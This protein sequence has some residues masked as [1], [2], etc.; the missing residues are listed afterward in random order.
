[1][2]M[3]DHYKNANS[4]E[5]ILRDHLAYDRTV[6]ANERTLL[7]YMRTAIMLLV[8]GGTLL[9]LFTKSYTTIILS[10]IFFVLCLIVG[11]IG[12]K[13]FLKTKTNLSG[14]YSDIK[15]QKN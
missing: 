14:I 13:K 8:T 10:A 6:L 1:M 12:L 2:Q 3:F 5:M 9:R 4:S 15:Q 11:F 7:A